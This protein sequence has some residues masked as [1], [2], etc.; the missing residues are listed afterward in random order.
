[1]KNILL[2][3]VAFIAVFLIVINNWDEPSGRYYSCRDI[4]FHPDVPPEVRVECRKLIREKLDDERRR[5]LNNT[6]YIT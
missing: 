6:G 4:E 1:M 2:V 5:N 3:I